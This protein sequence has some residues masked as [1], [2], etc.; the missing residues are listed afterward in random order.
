MSNKR[1]SFQMGNQFNGCGEAVYLKAD[2][3]KVPPVSQDNV[4][5]TPDYSRL[6]LKVIEGSPSQLNSNPVDEI[7]KAM[8]GSQTAVNHVALAKNME[9]GNYV[10]SFKVAPSRGFLADSYPT[11]QVLKRLL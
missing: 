10:A 8:L 9:D 1:S 3:V 7:I 11:N 6:A 2:L 4:Q 5:I